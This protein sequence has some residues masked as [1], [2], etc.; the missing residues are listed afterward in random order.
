MTAG[1]ARVNQGKPKWVS[2][3][4]LTVDD[5]MDLLAIFSVKDLF[6]F[7]A[8]QVASN[9]EG[10][11]CLQSRTGPTVLSQEKMSYRDGHWHYSTHD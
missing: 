9:M 2:C 11:A 4:P 1:G 10:S 8:R 5:A 6:P 3:S 7:L